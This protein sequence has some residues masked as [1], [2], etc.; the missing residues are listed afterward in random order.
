MIIASST[1]STR[2]F[3]LYA[4][5]LC[6]VIK[7]NIALAVSLAV[8]SSILILAIIL[9]GVTYYRY[10][11]LE[12]CTDDLDDFDY[13]ESVSRLRRLSEVK[14][15]VYVRASVLDTLGYESSVTPEMQDPTN[16]PRD[17]LFW[18]DISTISGKGQSI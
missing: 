17:S 8:I 15:D 4:P 16:T 13:L 12:S 1:S 5:S 9:L 14:S 3:T 6:E 18:V 11:V 2:F 7:L 10:A